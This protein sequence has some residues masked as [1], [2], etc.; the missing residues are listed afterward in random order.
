VKDPLLGAKNGKRIGK[1]L[2]IVVNVV[3]EIKYK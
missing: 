1:K 2:N 3:E